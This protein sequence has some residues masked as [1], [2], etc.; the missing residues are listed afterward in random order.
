MATPHVGAEA[1]SLTPPQYPAE[2]GLQV[3][4]GEVYYETLTWLAP[5]QSNLHALAL[6]ISVVHGPPELSSQA[7]GREH[8]RL[9]RSSWLCHFTTAAARSVQGQ[10]G[11]L[12]ARSNTY[13][14][15][16]LSVNELLCIFVSAPQ[17]HQNLLYAMR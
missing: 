1:S 15:A 7:V 17:A 12:Q 14:A 11:S 6:P 10:P 9:C 5:G 16:A 13:M 3:S 2:M 4:T 8:L